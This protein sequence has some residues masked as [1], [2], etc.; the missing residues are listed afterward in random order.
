MNGSSQLRT[1]SILL[2]ATLAILWLAIPQSVSNWSRDLLPDFAQPFVR[3][4][5][6]SV[7]TGANVT[8]LPLLYETARAWFQSAAKK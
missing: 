7:E 8:R 4:V 3:P 6:E 2:Y 1:V 5:V